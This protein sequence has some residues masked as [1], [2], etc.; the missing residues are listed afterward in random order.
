[1]LMVEAT[2]VPDVTPPAAV[3]HAFPQQCGRM[4][5]KNPISDPVTGP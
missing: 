3:G 5:A 1:M 4:G 2:A